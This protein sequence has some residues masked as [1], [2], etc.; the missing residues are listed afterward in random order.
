MTVTVCSYNSVN[1]SYLQF[2]CIYVNTF[3][4]TFVFDVILI[5]NTLFQV[6]TDTD[7]YRR[8]HLYE[9]LCLETD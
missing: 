1:I 5:Y 3:D 7:N 9:T 8:K 6:S 4:I 2:D